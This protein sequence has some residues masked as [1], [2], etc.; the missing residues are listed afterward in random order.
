[1][2]PVTGLESRQLAVLAKTAAGSVD[3]GDDSLD[4]LHRR[5]EMLGI[6]YHHVHRSAEGRSS[7]RGAGHDAP[8]TVL[9]DDELPVLADPVE[10]PDEVLEVADG[11]LDVVVDADAIV[12]D[13]ALTDDVPGWVSAATAGQRGHRDRARG[14]ERSCEP[15]T[16]TECAITFRNR[17]AS[18]RCRHHNDSRGCT[19]GN[20][21][22]V[23]AAMVHAASGPRRAHP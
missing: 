11:V 12:D 4:R 13:E 10:S 23:P 16:Q 20:C 6:R 19:D 17:D 1:M 9:A 7:M 21:V 8:L 3:C 5:S 15:A 22:Q 18:L 2:R 14:C